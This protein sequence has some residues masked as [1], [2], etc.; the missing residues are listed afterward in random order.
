[1]DSVLSFAFVLF[2]SFVDDFRRF[3]RR[4]LT[5]TIT[6]AIQAIQAILA[7]AIMISACG[8][9][10]LGMQNKY[11]RII[12]RMRGLSRERLDLVHRRGDPLADTRLASIDYQMPDLHLRNRRQ[13]N[14]ILLLYCA[15]IAFVADTFAIALGLFVQSWAT[16]ILAL[17]V[18][19]AGMLLVL[20][21]MIQAA[22][23]IRISTRAVTYETREALKL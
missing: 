19:L 11:G 22:L 21:S 16:T 10:L 14:A 3:R 2:A 23:E 13:H 7:P 20:L 8:L 4:P 17:G 1:M 15:V 5:T 12:D 18:F 9:L 6:Q